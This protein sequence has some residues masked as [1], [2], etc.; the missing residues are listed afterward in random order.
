MITVIGA[1]LAGAE[2]AFAAAELGCDVTLI[3]MKPGRFSPAHHSP[4]F[5]ELV[6]SNS[7]KAV[8]AD[9][10]AGLLKE[11]MRRLGS[12][13][14]SVADT[15]AVPAGGALAVDREA[16]AVGVTER[17]RGHSRITIVQKECMAL[18]E[19]GIVAT[20]PL[21]AGK[22]AGDVAALC[23]RSSGTPLYFYDAAAPIV[24]AESVDM[25]R[26]FTGV[27][28]G[29]GDDYIN[30]PMNK[31]QY[32]RFYDALITAPRAA[33]HDF[34]AMGGA[35][36]DGVGATA[37]ENAENKASANNAIEKKTPVYEGC[38][39]IETLAARG[40]DAIRFGPMKP[41]GLR[42]PDT[43]HRPWAV[44]Q[45]RREDA[46]GRLLGLVGFQTNLTFAAQREIFGLIP[47]LKNA[48]FIR[49]GVMHRNTFLPSPSLLG[50][51]FAL[52]G[53]PALFFAGQ[54]TGVEGYMESAASGLLAG[55][56]AA[57]REKG[58]NSLTLP[59][60]TMM[61]ALAAYI[62]TPTTDFQPMGAN[63]GL[64]P[65]LE[66][67]EKE[68]RKRYAALAQRALDDLAGAVAEG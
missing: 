28:Y 40:R 53:N 63:M 37:E 13:C 27:R 4:L 19:A 39:P 48:E 31:E 10:A 51:D 67:P 20:G 1:G 29:E 9:S 45:L 34:D 18:P 44:L 5:A 30:C 14:L 54:I 26:A 65:G 3:E 36:T 68:K 57:R 42:D 17:L 50:P 8:R 23:V 62:S 38:M 52:C 22:L 2:A 64:L 60:T 21:T 35:V 24:A 25:E 49:Y 32:E 16:F 6:C 43:G 56:N 33:L 47:A 12:L 46:A 55:I 15:C 41:V 11:E 59:R 7:F 58:W 61:G 66:H